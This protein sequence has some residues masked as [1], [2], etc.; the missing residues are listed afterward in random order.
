L[1]EEIDGKV[2]AVKTA[3][4]G[5]DLDEINRTAQ[6]LSQAMQRVGEAVYGQEGAAPPPGAEGE[7]PGEPGPGDEGTVEGEFREV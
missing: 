3:L 4:S 2:A 1:K 6:D 5:S 7:A